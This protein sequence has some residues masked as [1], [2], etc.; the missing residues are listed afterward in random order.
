MVL[1]EDLMPKIGSDSIN[2]A[3][4]TLYRKAAS[5]GSIE[6]YACWLES[7]MEIKMFS[8]NPR[9]YF[10]HHWTN[11]RLV[12]THLNKSFIMN[13]IWLKKIRIYF[14]NPSQSLSWCVLLTSAKRRLVK[15]VLVIGR[16]GSICTIMG[17]DER[18]SFMFHF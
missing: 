4:C 13:K 12:C 6:C 16:K 11:T 1:S 9:C 18:H 15:L 7:K 5:K 3:V 14:F 8:S 2:M 10:K 17:L